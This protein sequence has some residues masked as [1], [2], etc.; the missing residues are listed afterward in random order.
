MN[1]NARETTE[2]ATTV[3]ET[4]E[5]FRRPGVLPTPKVLL[6]TVPAIVLALFAWLVFSKV[7]ARQRCA[8][9]R[10]RLRRTPATFLSP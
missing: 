2:P 8:P 1:R 3:R 4:E 9:R 6:Y 10:L 7:Q 5:K